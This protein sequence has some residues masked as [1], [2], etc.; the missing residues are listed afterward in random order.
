MNLAITFLYLIVQLS[1]YLT[2]T[3]TYVL[4][5]NYYEFDEN[6]KLQQL[7]NLI[8]WCLKSSSQQTF[9]NRFMYVNLYEIVGN[10]YFVKTGIY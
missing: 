9:V 4:Q 5:I 8:S 1:L 2:F 6:V 10:I 7:S 3:S